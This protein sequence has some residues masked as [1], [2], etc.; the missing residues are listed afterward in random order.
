M[1]RRRRASPHLH[2]WKL[3]GGG[4]SWTT[5]EDANNFSTRWEMKAGGTPALLRAPHFALNLAHL[6]LRPQS[7]ARLRVNRRAD[8]LAGGG[9]QRDRISAR[10]HLLRAEQPQPR[11][12]R[13]HPAPHFAQLMVNHLPQPPFLFLHQFAPLGQVLPGPHA[14]E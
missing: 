9:I 10:E 7:L 1:L 14:A 5:T 13:R 3:G 6:E 8:D 4:E 2:F 11:V 12:K